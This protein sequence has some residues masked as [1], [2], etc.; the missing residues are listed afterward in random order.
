MREIGVQPHETPIAGLVDSGDGV[1]GR[2]RRLAVD[3]QIALAA[4]FDHG[5]AH[6]D[7]DILALPAAQFP[8]LRGSEPGRGDTG[9]RRSG[10]AK[11]RRQL[12]LLS[13]QRDGIERGRIAAGQSPEVGQNF[14]GALHGED[15]LRGVSCIYITGCHH[16]RKR[17]IQYAAA[18]QFNREGHGVLDTRFRG[19]DD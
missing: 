14:A 2:R 17:M 12:R 4:A 9:L 15:S 18:S 6:V 13:R 8:D 10:D 7:G 3:A 11:R 5:V 19:Y 16:P 1:P